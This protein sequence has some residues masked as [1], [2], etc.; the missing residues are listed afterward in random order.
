MKTSYYSHGKLLISG[1]YAVLD[2]GLGL[3]IPTKYGQTL[4]IEPHEKPMLNWTSYDLQGNVWFETQISMADLF[5]Q[6]DT[7][8]SQESI[9]GRLLNILYEARKLNQAFLT[10][11]SGY[12][13]KARLEF[14]REWGLGSS[15]TL[16]NNI[17]QWAAVNAFALH[18]KSF[19]GSGYD[20]AC[21]Q[22]PSPILFQR[23][24]PLP[25]VEEIAFDPP[26][27]DLLFFVYL[28]RKQNSRNAIRAYQNSKSRAAKF[29]S[30]SSSIT[31]QFIQAK[32]LSDFEEAMNTHEKM[33]SATLNIPTVGN[34]LFADF[35]GS[36]KS[37]GAWGGDFI[38]A[39]GGEESHSYFRDK[40]YATLIP[41]AEM[42]L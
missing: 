41:W 19:G 10:G 34:T 11:N 38:L 2:G 1:E 16:I 27:R 4:Q 26:F 30:E 24:D 3:A 31:R 17:A 14:P 42:I 15:S 25:Q 8:N 6:P 13:V 5:Y 28:N 9:K 18:Q 12:S 7:A 22:H 40:G 21:A 23:Q 20:I 35:R 36:T 39:T 29:I 32:T 33:V 37:L